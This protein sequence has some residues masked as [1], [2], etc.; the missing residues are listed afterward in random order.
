MLD[1]RVGVF[2]AEASILNNF[3]R[4]NPDPTENACRS[5][6]ASFLF[7]A[8]AALQ[9]VGPLSGGQKVR[10]GLACNRGWTDRQ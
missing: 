8:V 3:I 6:L 1:Q 9:R 5:T 7:R 10:A 4:L 2:D